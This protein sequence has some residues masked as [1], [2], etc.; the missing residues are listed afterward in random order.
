MP[1]GSNSTAADGDC[2]SVSGFWRFIES[3]A[4]W[5]T[6]GIGRPRRPRIPIGSWTSKMATPR[7]GLTL[8][9]RLLGAAGGLEAKRG[10]DESSNTATPQAS[11]TCREGEIPIANGSDSPPRRMETVL[12]H[13]QR[14]ARPKQPP[15]KDRRICHSLQ[16]Q[17]RQHFPPAHP[18]EL[19]GA[20]RRP[21]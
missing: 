6:A 16:S 13:H 7:Q 2:R 19:L 11:A 21:G 8:A 20:I 9:G 18:R 12:R 15:S 3:G 14:G 1:L 5:P 10:R 4:H 17:P